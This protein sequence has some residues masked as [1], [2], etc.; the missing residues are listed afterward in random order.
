MTLRNDGSATWKPA[1]VD[2]VYLSGPKFQKN[3]ST[4]YLTKDILPGQ[5]VKLLVDMVAT[6]ARG[7]QN[8]NWALEQGSGAYFCYVGVTV[9]IK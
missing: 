8:I 3:S 6:S 9:K 2:F 5:S 1:T 7:M 4:I